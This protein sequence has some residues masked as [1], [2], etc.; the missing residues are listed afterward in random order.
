[1]VSALVLQGTAQAIFVL[2]SI[3]VARLPTQAWAMACR[4]MMAGLCGLGIWCSWNLARADY[5]YH[6]DTVASLRA[7]LRLEPDAWR[8]SMRLAAMDDGDAQQL[9]ETTLR[10]YPYNA[11]ADIDLGLR[12]EAAGNDD[13]AEK[14]LL[15][16]YSVDHTF[17]PRWSLANFYL[18]RNNLPAFW[19]WARKAA[20]MPYDNTQPLF[21][22]CWHVSPDPGEIAQRILNNNP[23]LL[24]QY[25]SFLLAK[26]QA[27]AAAAIA[28]RLT[29]FGS[30]KADAPQMFAVIDR[31]IAANNGQ[32]AQ[33]L[34]QTLIARRWV[35]ADQSTPNNASFAREPLPVAF[36][37]ALSSYEGLQSW[38]G[39]AGLETEFS[40]MQPENCTIAEQ[41]VVLPPGNYQLAYAYRTEQISPAT[42]LRWQILP[43]GS[44]TPLAESHD[45]SSDTLSE[46]KFAFTVSPGTSALRLR[47]HYQ[48]ALGTTR[49]AGTAVIESVQIHAAS[50]GS[51][52]Q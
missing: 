39:P 43:V 52:Q 8:Y 37:W 36:D 30:P 7:A 42:G 14:L 18:R 3:A 2:G 10:L 15:D 23:T 44:E 35:T 4:A 40:G 46:G 6:L 49:I 33:Q 25:I 13:A 45:L 22:L 19:L 28:Q 51:A 29:Q 16:A 5:L 12:Q 38:P 9:L 20:E 11:E 26:N 47:L 50:S 21:E 31:L 27:P 17:M 34:W 32:A 48:R 24:R 41:F 1:M